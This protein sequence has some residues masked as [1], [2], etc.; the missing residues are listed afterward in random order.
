MPLFFLAQCVTLG[1]QEGA[2]ENV[3]MNYSGDQGQAIK[4]LILT[5]C[6]R[7]V[8]MCVLTSPHGKRQHLAVS[9]EKG[10]I[11]ILQLSSLL[12]QAD[13]SKKKLTLTVCVWTVVVVVVVSLYLSCVGVHLF[14]FHL[15]DGNF[16]RFFKALSALFLSW[17]GQQHTGFLTSIGCHFCHTTL[18]MVDSPSVP[19]VVDLYFERS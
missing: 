13:S 6:L 12:K 18:W 5:H 2:F 19:L 16:A 9:H 1:S 4:Q 7:R 10:K 3:R 15:F 14:A 17:S 11:T 8:A